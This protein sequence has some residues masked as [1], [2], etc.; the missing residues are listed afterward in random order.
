VA[1]IG[2]TPRRLALDDRYAYASTL[3][4]RTVRLGRVPKSGGP[5]EWLATSDDDDPVDFAPADAGVFWETSGSLWALPG[6]PSADRKP[7]SLGRIAPPYDPA[8]SQRLEISDL[9]VRGDTT[10][11]VQRDS[12]SDGAQVVSHSRAHG[13]RRILGLGLTRPTL[14]RAD[15]HAVYFLDAGIH[16]VAKG[17]PMIIGCCSIWTAPHSRPRMSRN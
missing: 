9:A 14:L 5:V 15:D 12:H 2:G 3:E 8:S 16:T 17:T 10:F 6:A 7:R 4:G 13:W 11:Y 1:E